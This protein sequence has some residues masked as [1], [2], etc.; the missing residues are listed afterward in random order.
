[1][2]IEY[3]GITEEKIKTF[4]PLRDIDINNKV[5]TILG[6][7]HYGP[8]FGTVC[9]VTRVHTKRKQELIEDLWCVV[10]SNED[11]TDTLLLIPY[12]FVVNTGGRGEWYQRKDKFKFN[13]KDINVKCIGI[14]QNYY[15]VCEFE[16]VEEQENA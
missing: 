12:R 13:N 1:M 9:K 16:Y 5:K 2:R 11:Y 15:A 4:T 7:V 3:L 6:F 14:Y 10:V 8:I